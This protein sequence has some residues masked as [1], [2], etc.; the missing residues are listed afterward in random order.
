YDRR[1]LERTLRSAG[2]EV[3][4]LRYVNPVGA[5]GWLVSSRLL[6]RSQVPE[7]PLTLYDKLVPVFRR[8]DALRLPFGLSLWAVAQA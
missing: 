2:F 1:G 5:A 3:V 7:G 6:R 4:E 8:L